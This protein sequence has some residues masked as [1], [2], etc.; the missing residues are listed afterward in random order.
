M[1]FNLDCYIFD[2]D[3][4]FVNENRDFL[5]KSMF[6]LY[7]IFFIYLLLFIYIYKYIL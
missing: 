7:L 3:D 1:C 5:R 4:Q 2:N 6:L